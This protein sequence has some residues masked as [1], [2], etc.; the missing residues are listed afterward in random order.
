MKKLSHYHVLI[1]DDEHFPR[2]ALRRYFEKADSEFRVTAEASD[3]LEALD[4]LQKTD[5][6]VVI[7]DIRMPEMD[8]LELV[9]TAR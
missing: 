4:I 1:V 6:E 8:D 2:Q 5:I 9:K 3:G 7:T